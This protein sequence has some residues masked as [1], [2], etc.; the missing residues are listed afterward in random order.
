MMK[1]E[2]QISS[3]AGRNRNTR[4]I[5][6]LAL[7][8]V[9][10]GSLTYASVPLYQLFCQVTGYGGTTQV[11]A[12]KSETVIN[13]VLKVQFDGTVNPALAWSFKPAQ[14]SVRLKVGENGL[15]FYRARNNSDETIVG[16]AS[17]NVTPDKAGLYFNKVECFCFTE[18]VLKSGEEVDMP[19]SFFIDPEIVDDPNLDDVTTITLSYT[20]FRAEDQSAGELVAQ[21]NTDKLAGGFAGGTITVDRATN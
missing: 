1:G 5:A 12:Q 18:Q 13:R 15:A 4:T 19:V 8:I 6:V 7:L 9:A 16:T 14:R 3:Q 11:A 21:A 20:F 2:T 10:M 17:F